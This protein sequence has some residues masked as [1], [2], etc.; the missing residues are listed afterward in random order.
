MCVKQ[1]MR[2]LKSLLQIIR[3]TLFFSTGR[4]LKDAGTDAAK[5]AEL[6]KASRK[7]FLKSTARKTLPNSRNTSGKPHEFLKIEEAGFTA[8]VN[9]FIRNR[10]SVLKQASV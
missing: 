5:K 10:I 1:G 2:F 7:Q 9:K 8:L 3:R 6:V 4:L